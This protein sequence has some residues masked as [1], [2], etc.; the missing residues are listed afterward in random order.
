MLADKLAL[1]VSESITNI[2]NWETSNNYTFTLYEIFFVLMPYRHAPTIPRLEYIL[3]VV[4][5]WENKNV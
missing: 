3:S 5:M 1:K 2:N 4:Q